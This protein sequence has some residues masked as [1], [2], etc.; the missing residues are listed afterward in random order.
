MKPTLTH[1]DYVRAAAV[2]GVQ[3]AVIKAVAAVEAPR[4]GFLASGE[5]TILYER[6]IFSRLTGGKYDNKWPSIS[7]R[8]PGGYIGGYAEH[9]RLQ[10][11]V[12]LDRDAALQ[13]ASWGKFQIMGFN[14]AACGCK[15]LQ[16]FINLVYRSEQAQ[17]GLFINFLRSQGLVKYSKALDFTGFA[18][19]YN[20]PAY[21]RYSYDVKLRAAYRRYL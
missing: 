3:V 17:L 16:E 10:R 9:L 21:A 6:H 1:E 18:R 13:S 8:I 7:N 20:G 12:E 15:T 14:Y 4:G 2:L 11:A 19:R 5:P